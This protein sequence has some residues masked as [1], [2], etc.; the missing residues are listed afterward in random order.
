[1]SG[2]VIQISGQAIRPK[3]WI[4]RL[5]AVAAVGGVGL[6]LYACGG[7]SAPG[8]VHGYV[9]PLA[10]PA[11]GYREATFTATVE[12]KLRGHVLATERVAP[13]KQ[14]HFTEPAGTYTLTAAGHSSCL[15]TVTFVARRNEEMD[16]LCT[17]LF[18]GPVPG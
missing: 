12:I 15:T 10:G 5:A 2:M 4:R 11:L 18:R 16:L 6:A 7:G 8:T 14:F 3:Q 1:M 13:G 9:M 17:P